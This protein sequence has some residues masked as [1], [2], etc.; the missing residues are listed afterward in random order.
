[1]QGGMLGASIGRG[2][3]RWERFAPGISV[4]FLIGRIGYALQQ[5]ASRLL[6][7]AVIEAV[8]LALMLGMVW[9]NVWGLNDS[10]QRGVTFT[11]K[12]ILIYA[13]VLLGASVDLPALF[14]AGPSLLAAVV[15]LVGIGLFA[16]LLIGRVIGLNPRLALLVAVRN[17]ICGSP[18][19][20]AVAPVIKADKEAVAS[21][22][23]LTAILSVGVVLRLPLLLP[24]LNVSMYQYGVLAGMTVYASLGVRS[25]HAVGVAGRRIRR[26][27]CCRITARA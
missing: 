18:A 11:G 16:G 7:L 20:A 27:G 1:M 8:V 26:H 21:A 6:G 23:A 9:R 12:T 5:Q 14:Q 25:E 2:K 15:V 17:S 24:L 3:Q 10:L 22:I 19:I 4:S 13:V